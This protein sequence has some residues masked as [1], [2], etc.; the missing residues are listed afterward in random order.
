M[1]RR[2]KKKWLYFNSEN[3]IVYS[4]NIFFSC[5]CVLQG[6][7]EGRDSPPAEFGKPSGGVHHSGSEEMGQ[8]QPSPFVVTARPDRRDLT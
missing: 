1:S 5:D 8:R 4:L 6:T 2:P 7:A 3:L